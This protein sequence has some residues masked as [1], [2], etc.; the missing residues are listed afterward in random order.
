MTNFL[1]LLIAL[2]ICWLAAKTTTTNEILKGI[3][4]IMA[5]INDELAEVNTHLTEASA[6]ILAL[7]AD[8]EKERLTPAGRTALNEIKAKATALKDI[9]LPTPA[10]PP[11]P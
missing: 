2:S 10:P 5:N 7:I 1:L 4:K 6:E 9:V 11:E 3:Q 8:L